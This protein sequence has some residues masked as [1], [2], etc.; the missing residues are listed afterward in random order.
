[1]RRG[2]FRLLEQAMGHHPSS[3][4][5]AEHVCM[6]LDNLA[7]E[8]E[9]R[10][11]L[12]RLGAVGLVTQAMCAHTL[13]EEVQIW[14]CSALLNLAKD[15]TSMPELTFKSICDAVSR[16]PFSEQVHHRACIALGNF[17]LVVR[18]KETL[19]RAGAGRT[20]VSSMVAHP[21]SLAVQQNCCQALANLAHKT[22]GAAAALLELGVAGLVAQ[23]MARH[24]AC[25]QIQLLGCS[26]FVCLASTAEACE[27]LLGLGVVAPIVRAMATFG[28]T[29]SIGN[30]GRL[31]L[32]KLARGSGT[33]DAAVRHSV[34]QSIE[35]TMRDPCASL[36]MCEQACAELAS[37]A[38]SGSDACR[39]EMIQHGEVDW[40][41]DAMKAHTA[42]LSIQTSGCVVIEVTGKQLGA[43]SIVQ[44]AVTAVVQAMLAHP[45]CE[46][47]SER[48]CTALDYMMYPS[49]QN[50]AIT[51]QPQVVQVLLKAL[52]THAANICVQIRA[53]STL[54]SLAPMPHGRAEIMRPEVLRPLLRLIGDRHNSREVCFIMFLIVKR[55]A[56]ASEYRSALI[57]EGAVSVTL[58]AMKDHPAETS[59]QVNAC[60]ILEYLACPMITR[61]ELGRQGV[62]ET[63]VTS[64]INHASSLQIQQLVTAAL[65][66]LASAPENVVEM[67]LQGVDELFELALMQHPFEER[68]KE[69][70]HI[71]RQR[72]AA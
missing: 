10:S 60:S 34:L 24:A 58:Q 13:S 71:A 61:A 37:R 7:R 56:S 8:A 25:R 41:I 69:R 39:R 63:L 44:R 22:P 6:A 70:V 20:L 15:S 12:L 55:L 5:I 57:R 23:A 49:N 16:H 65:S 42:S 50:N 46:H 1:V 32:D 59:V 14:G 36:S 17:A 26:L 45:S 62:V 53:C 19:L 3:E 4:K 51:N 21:C 47:L 52:L 35:A 66:H 72:L 43:S 29:S 2:A 28:H 40:L 27:E 18:D 54:A 33:A 64:M 48:G 68:F 9:A 30:R 38:R 31:A 67:T 11:K